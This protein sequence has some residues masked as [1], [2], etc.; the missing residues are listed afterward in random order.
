MDFVHRFLIWN[1]TQLLPFAEVPP[2]LDIIRNH[3][4]NKE[5]MEPLFTEKAES[6]LM[7]PAKNLIL[8]H[9]TLFFEVF[10]SCYCQFPFTTS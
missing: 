6:L 2:C 3:L 10:L 1:A 5:T 9:M 8:C 4:I 7:T